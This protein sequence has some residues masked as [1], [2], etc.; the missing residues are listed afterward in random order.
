VKPPFGV[1]VQY[2]PT[3]GLNLKRRKTEAIE[4]ITNENDLTD[5]GFRIE[6]IV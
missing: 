3:S 2:I 5:R 4:K 6:D 1:A